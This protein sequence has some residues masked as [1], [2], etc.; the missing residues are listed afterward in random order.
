MI[1]LDFVEKNVLNL[2][3]GK[4]QHV[5]KRFKQYFIIS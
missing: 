5:N 4:S 3:F 1:L 2:F